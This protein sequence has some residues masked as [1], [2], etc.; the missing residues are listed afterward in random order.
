M[1]KLQHDYSAGKLALGSFIGW[2][3]LALWLSRLPSLSSRDE[4]TLSSSQP[5]T[6]TEVSFYSNFSTSHTEVAKWQ[7]TSRL[8][9]ALEQWISDEFLPSNKAQCQFWYHNSQKIMCLF[10]R[11]TEVL[12]YSA[13]LLHCT[14][15]KQNLTSVHLVLITLKF[16]TQHCHQSLSLSGTPNT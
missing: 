2:T 1:F 11:Y 4:L 8:K 9:C 7:H 5:I 6:C 12:W 13:L 14:E 15:K 3:Q 10:S 16:S